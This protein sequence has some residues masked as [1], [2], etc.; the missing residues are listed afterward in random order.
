VGLLHSNFLIPLSQSTGAS[1]ADGVAQPKDSMDGPQDLPADV[2][3]AEPDLTICDRE[4]ITRL[5]RIQSFGFLVALSNDWTVVRT[6]ENLKA[7]LGVTVEQAL[8]QRF[9][10]LISEQATHDIRNRMAI[11]F[12]TGAERLY[13]VRLLG[14]SGLSISVSI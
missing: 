9:N 4:P 11:L 10:S 1:G 7:F 8:G 5:D 2:T 14:D 12:S 13:G 3:A 6:S